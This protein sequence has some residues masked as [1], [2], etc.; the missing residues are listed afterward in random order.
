LDLR[1]LRYFV[2]LATQRSFGRAAEVLRIAQP[3]LS[4]QIKLLEAELGV[5]L[6]ERHMH[7]ASPT[8]EALQLLERAMFLIRYADQTK[9][10]MQ[11]FGQVPKGA[12]SLGLPPALA[13]CLSVPLVAHVAS[14]YPE[15]SLRIVES[16]SPSLEKKLTSGQVDLAIINGPTTLPAIEAH[17]LLREA[18]C[19]ILPFSDERL[20]GDVVTVEA[21][22]GVPLV[23]TGIAKSGI[24][25][26]L[27][28]AASRRNQ[29]LN[30]V[31]EVES[32]AVAKKLV[33]NGI[34]WT[35]HVATTIADEMAVKSLKAVTLEGCKLERSLATSIGRPQSRATRALSDSIRCVARELIANGGLPNCELMDVAET[36]SQGTPSATGNGLRTV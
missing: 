19:V 9:A 27:E 8:A 18:I 11:A 13:Q 7:G 17:P 36:G 23:L 31:V 14:A 33:L 22:A 15:I 5:R 10:E 26:E 12:V 16:F 35:V 4:R 2:T 24:R 20:M 3:A 28:I 32:I 25:S 30:V 29:A 21:L 1:Q 6:F 34:G